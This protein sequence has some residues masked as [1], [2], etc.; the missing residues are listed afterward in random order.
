MNS[1]HR[2]ILAALPLLGL[3]TAS[4]HIGYGGRD[5]GTFV[6]GE[7]PVTITN[8]VVAGA[9]GWADGTDA[10]FSDSHRLRAFR[11]TLAATATVTISV[12][13]IAFTGTTSGIA[14]LL[15]AFSIYEGLAHVS[16]AAA[17]HDGSA[18]SI[19]YLASLPGPGKEGALRSLN[20]WK[21]G[22]DDNL[23]IPE[24]SSFTYKAHAADGTAANYGSEPGIV[25]DGIAD[26]IV[27]GTATLPAGDYT[28][29]VGGADYASGVGAVA[30][31]TN[32]GIRTTVTAVP[33]P[34]SA[35]LLLTGAAFLVRRR[36]SGSTT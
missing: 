15:P 2:T 20:D 34:S 23:T 1:I 11:F 28:L 12:E 6:G 29:F 9:F 25:G 22:S 35:L 16:P 26:G 24:M 17:D 30:P 10:D 36:R 27:T 31:F 7:A 14:G 18:M 21:I 3:S 13:S 32:Y 19:F 4:A 33:E 8:Q 5:F